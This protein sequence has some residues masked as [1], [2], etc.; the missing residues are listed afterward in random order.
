MKANVAIAEDNQIVLLDPPLPPE[1]KHI[2]HSWMAIADDDLIQLLD[3]LMSDNADHDLPSNVL[4][5]RLNY[6]PPADLF[7]AHMVKAC[8]KN[9]DLLEK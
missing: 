1:P 5:S 2:S 3:P 6:L 4:T 8:I 9:I 7:H